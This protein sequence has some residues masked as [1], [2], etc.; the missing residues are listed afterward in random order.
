MPRRMSRRY[1]A[2]DEW[3][4]GDRAAWR[5]AIAKGDILDG[6]GPAAHWADATK[7]TNLQHYSRWL[8]FLAAEAILR[9]DLRP[10]ERVTPDAVRAY[11]ARLQAEI[12][13]RTVV[14]ALV[15]LKVVIKA[16]APHANWRWLADVC[17]ALNRRSSP[18]KDKRMRMRPTGEI[19]AAAFAEL[20]RLSKTALR[21]RNDRVAFRDTLM[22]AILAARPVRLRNLAEIRIGG[23]LVRQGDVLLLAFP[24]E[25]VKNRR[26]LEYDLPV[27]VVS[28]LQT[29]LQRIRPSFLK[30]G[31]SDALW[32]GFEGKPLTPHSIYGRIMLVSERLLGVAINPHLLR[33][34]AATSLA[35]VSPAA[36]L[37]AAALLGHQSFATTER[38]YIRANQLEAGR[39][40]NAMLAD[41]RS[42][43]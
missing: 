12:A 41:I 4:S 33:D 15:G 14:S 26:P 3:P 5:A 35:T 40:V 9:E 42:Q 20:G 17:N 31:V 38:Y 2:F 28:F 37:S 1:L 23:H 25:E 34:C 13:P 24:A 22:L 36:A 39:V 16:M 43:T 19:Y 18:S 7:R 32:L 27:S 6:Q 10:D 21:R 11:V 29:Y 8:R 30:G